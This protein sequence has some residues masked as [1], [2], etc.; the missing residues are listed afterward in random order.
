MCELAT[1]LAVAGTAFSAF[2]QFQNSQAQAGMARHNAAVALQTAQL[3]EA[4]ERERQSRAYSLQ[5]VKMMRGIQ[6]GGSLFDSLNDA[7]EGNEVQARAIR[8]EGQIQAQNFEHQAK[9]Q[10]WNAGMSLIGSG[11]NIGQSLLGPARGV[12]GAGGAGATSGA[13]TGASR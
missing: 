9:M 4:Q 8:R 2:T 6:P 11:F 13:T 5:R 7:F 3:R 10:D 1:V 12:L